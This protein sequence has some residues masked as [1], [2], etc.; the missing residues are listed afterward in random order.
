MKKFLVI[1]MVVAMASFLFVGCIP[2]VTPVTPDVDDEEPVVPTSATP[3]LTD[4]ESSAAVEI[5][6][7]TSTSTL[8]MNED[9]AGS[10]ILVKGTAPSGSLVTIYIDDVAIVGAVGET[11]VTGLWTVAVAESSLGAD[12]VKVMTAKV[13]E[14]GLAE[15]AASNAVT[16]T[17]DTVDPGI[18]SVAATAAVA[19]GT[20]VSGTVVSA[21][22]TGTN[23]ITA[24]T[25]AGTSGT[26]VAGTWTI[27]VW[28]I[29]GAADNVTITSSSGTLTYTLV[30]SET[31]TDVIPGVAFTFAALVA[32]NSCTVT[33][34]ADTLATTTAILPRAT[35]TFDED[36]SHAGM[37]AGVYAVGGVAGDPTSYKEATDTGYWQITTAAAG[38]TLTIT[39]YGITD[40]AGNVGGTSASVLT[41]SCTVAAAS[42]TSLAP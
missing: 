41:A 24:L 11:A 15:S 21:T 39:V 31:F 9:E 37:A 16:F 36:V 23:P 35:I 7:V 25:L 14:V 1:L 3:V 34:T 8:Y 42:A 4:V 17:L 22:V 26:M 28:G 12:G 10:S 6:D 2:G 19:G 38:A 33:T 32:G 13:T 5:F 27:E 29:S 30:G 20:A 18:D 40:L